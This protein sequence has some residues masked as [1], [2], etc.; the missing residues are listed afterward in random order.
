MRRLIL[1]L[2]ISFASVASAQL[3]SNAPDELVRSLTERVTGFYSDFQ[4]GQFRHAESFVDEESKE[5]YY[6]VRKVRIMGHTIREFTWSDDFRSVRVMVTALTLVPML[7]STPL[8]IPVGSEWTLIDGE[9]YMHLTP[10]DG[11]RM[12]PFGQV[13]PAAPTAGGQGTGSLQPGGMAAPSVASLGN[14]ISLDSTE[15][16]FPASSTE[17][18]TQVVGVTSHAPAGF[19]LTI[20]PLRKL[21]AGLTVA[22]EPVL[23]EAGGKATLSITYDPAIHVLSGRRQLDF[24]V[25][26]TG[27]RLRVVAVFERAEPVASTDQ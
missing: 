11:R 18:I 26:P 20:E 23:I 24:E 19:N 2:A 16:T 5:L 13:N 22:I 1:I 9:W 12:T 4:N 3:E 17:P 14:M 27:Q 15:T 10:P 7:G 8:P 21:P 6:N 25:S